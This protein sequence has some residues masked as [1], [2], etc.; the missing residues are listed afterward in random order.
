MEIIVTI[1]G[2]N[3]G[4]KSDERLVGSVKGYLVDAT[5][6]VSPAVY[7]L[8][9]DEDFYFYYDEKLKR[10]KKKSVRQQVLDSLILGYYSGYDYRIIAYSNTAK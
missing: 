8:L 9:Q 7:E 10:K 4:V 6:H 2:Q 1:K 3:F 5:M